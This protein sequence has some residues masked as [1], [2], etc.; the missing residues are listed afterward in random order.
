MSDDLT[1]KGPEDPKKVNMSQTWEMD[2]WSQKFGI[3]KDKL[4]KAIA[5]VGPMVA[6]IKAWLAKN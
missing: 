5:A 3:S 1:R 4:L 2:Y 6:D